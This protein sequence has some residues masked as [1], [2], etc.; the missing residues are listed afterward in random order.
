MKPSSTPRPRTLRGLGLDR[1]RALGRALN[2]DAR[3]VSTAAAVFDRLAVGWAQAPFGS[4]PSFPSDITD[5]HT[6]FEFS[7]ALARGVPELRVLSEAQGDAPGLAANWDAALGLN[8]RLAADYGV[9][10]ERFSEVV[11]LFAPTPRCQRFSIWHAACFTRAGSPEFKVYLNPQAAGSEQATRCVQRAMTRLGLG[12]AFEQVPALGADDE[13]CYFS[14]DLTASQR[15]RVKLYVA[16]R[17]A[18]LERIERAVAPALGSV[19]GR[20]SAFCENLSGSS[21]PYQARPVLTC[22]SFV[23]GSLRPSAATVHFPLRSY[24]ES[25]AL[26]KERVSALLTAEERAVYARALH[27][28][29][30]RPLALRSGMQTYASLRLDESRRVTVYLA[31]EAYTATGGRSRRSPQPAARRS[32]EQTP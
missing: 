17:H 15:A 8:R 26:G 4:A 2:L 21:G 30:R 29:A 20:A 27:A 14:L 11:E 12:A 5:D 13:L 19:T 9:C 24:A 3:A 28:F 32:L 16:H 10:L 22:L 6:P 25:D 23:A 31:P 18:T 1:L 7:V